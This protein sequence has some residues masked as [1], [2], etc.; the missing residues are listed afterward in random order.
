MVGMTTTGSASV[1]DYGG[2]SVIIDVAGVARQ[3]VSKT[4]NYQVKVPYSQINAGIRNIAR[5]G[6]KVTKVTVV[7][8]GSSDTPVAA[9]AA[10]D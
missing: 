6:G 4:S 9:S 1:S 7:G 3:D 8:V 10:D 5:L 2:R